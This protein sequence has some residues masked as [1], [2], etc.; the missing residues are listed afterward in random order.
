MTREVLEV[1][2]GSEHQAQATQRLMD[3]DLAEVEAIEA[4]A[5]RAIV[6][7]NDAEATLGALGPPRPPPAWAT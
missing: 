5:E 6:Y 2:F 4:L 7:T 3:L 1:R